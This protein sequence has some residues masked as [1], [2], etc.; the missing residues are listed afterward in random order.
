MRR[1][2]RGSGWWVE[3]AACVAGYPL[4]RRRDVPL[5][6]AAQAAWRAPIL[7][8][9]KGSDW[10]VRLPGFQTLRRTRAICCDTV[11]WRLSKAMV[12][13]Q[14]RAGRR[15]DRRAWTC[16][17]RAEFPETPSQD[18]SRLGF[19]HPRGRMLWRHATFVALQR[20]AEIR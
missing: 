14:S 15:R 3:F 8:R 20:A 4:Q 10:E 9:Q 6:I 12:H 19:R 13:L 1:R 5:P 18:R 17:L 11:R 2:C 16:D 7:L